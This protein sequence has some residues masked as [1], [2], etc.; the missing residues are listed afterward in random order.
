MLI[1]LNCFCRFI[2]EFEILHGDFQ[3]LPDTMSFLKSLA[4]LDTSY[5]SDKTEKRQMRERKAAA[6]VF[7]WEVV[8]TKTIT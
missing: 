7:N 5:D 3:G 6:G 8:I 2:E 4:E 1:L